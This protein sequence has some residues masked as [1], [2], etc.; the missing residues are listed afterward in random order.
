MSGG[1]PGPVSYLMSSS[2]C[3]WTVQRSKI[4]FLICSR[5][6][7][8]CSKHW[9][10]E[11]LSQAISLH[12][13]R[14][15]SIIYPEASPHLKKTLLIPQ[16]YSWVMLSLSQDTFACQHINVPVGFYRMK[17]YLN[18]R[19]LFHARLQSGAWTEIFM[20][21]YSDSHLQ[22]MKRISNLTC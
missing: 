12:G 3:F 20:S 6:K 2:S 4:P 19:R 1:D 11:C 18:T 7:Q 22:E 5:E 16:R 9:H 10:N 8:I 14:V 21:A 15:C 13:A 17:T